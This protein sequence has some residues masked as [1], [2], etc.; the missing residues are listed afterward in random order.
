MPLNR[1][2][3]VGCYRVVRLLTQFITSYQFVGH[4]TKFE[5]N[6]GQQQ[7]NN[8]EHVGNIL[9]VYILGKKMVELLAN[10]TTSPKIL[11]PE[12]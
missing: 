5:I 2:E 8:P 1:I 7:Q 10:R 9:T 6:H 4:I 11:R 3:D 12:Y